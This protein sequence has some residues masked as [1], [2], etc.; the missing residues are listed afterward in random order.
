MFLISNNFEALFGSGPQQFNEYLYGEKIY[1][2][3]PDYK[4]N[5]LYLPHSSLLDFMIFFGTIGTG[6]ILTYVFYKLYKSK[7]KLFVY[8]TGYLLINL[9]KSDSILYLNSFILTTTCIALLSKI[10]EE[11][12][13]ER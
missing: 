2:D 1:L 8:L 7:N 11:K 3:V 9:L 12:F 13:Y 4:M 5:S 6:I 10:K